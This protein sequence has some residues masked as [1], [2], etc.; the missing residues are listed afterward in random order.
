[1]TD[2]RTHICGMLGFAR[3][4]GK[5]TIGTESVCLAM[6]KRGAMRPYLILVSHAASDGTKKKVA[7]KGDYYGLPVRELPLDTEEIGHLLGKTTTPATLAVHD[8]HIA[9]ELMR[10]TCPVTIATKG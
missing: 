2:G 5:L 3:R 1:M 4:A 8:A 9:E 10:S 7:T 6:A